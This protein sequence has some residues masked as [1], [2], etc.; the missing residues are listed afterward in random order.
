MDSQPA[1][2]ASSPRPADKWT[3]ISCLLLAAGTLVV[4][5]RAASCEFINF[6]DP[7]YVVKNA[8][9]QAGL[10]WDTIKWA[11]TSFAEANWHPLTW[12]S[13]ALDVQLFH[14]NPAGHHYVNVL[15]HA[16]SV[17]ILFLA[18]LAATRRIWP[19]FMVAA[20]WA[21]HPLNVESVAW[22]A[23][24]KN[25]LSMFFFLLALYAYRWYVASPKARRYTVVAPLFALGLMAKPQVITFPCV[26]LLWDYWPLQRLRSSSA[27]PE[28]PARSFSWLVR[29]K[30]PLFLLVAA[31]AVITLQAQR[32]GHAVR[33]TAEFSLASRLENALVA[34]VRYIQFTVWPAGLSPVYPHPENSI[35][36]WQAACAAALLALITAL[37]LWQ[38]QRRY[39]LVGWLWF[40][41]TLVPMIGLVQV[42]QQAMADRY[43]Y[44]PLLGLL[45]MVVWGVAEL[46][47]RWRIPSPYVAVVAVSVLL[48]LAIVTYRQLG[49][50][51][52]S[53][54]LWTR[55]LAVTRNNYTAHGNLADAL[56]RQ[57][58]SEEAIVHYEA[59]ARLHAY[60]RLWSWCWEGM[61]S[62]MGTR[63]KPLRISSR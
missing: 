44:L 57:Q 43:A 9:V 27:S 3:L 33:T 26:L 22:V 49:Y 23:E 11:L 7:E 61:S 30:L 2:S 63:R 55:A 17:V 15:F 13:H 10:T 53:E 56:A 36:S 38:K 8:H 59:A 41:G 5:N 28:Y 18:L 31:S 54:S 32:L 21:L 4:Y 19:S 14:M 25:V 37:A 1:P 6:D 35:A 39:L 60:E 58:R 45:I 29:E 50:W 46:I 20:L 34:Y 42:G 40:L 12:W 52:T 62:R 24:R 47:A 51:H 48:A 16:A